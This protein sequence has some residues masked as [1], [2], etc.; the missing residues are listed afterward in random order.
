MEW[1]IEFIFEPFRYVKEGDQ[2]DQFC[3]AELR[4]IRFTLEENPAS[5]NHKIESLCKNEIN[6]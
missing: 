2:G 4:G 6:L 3:V 1:R 5:S